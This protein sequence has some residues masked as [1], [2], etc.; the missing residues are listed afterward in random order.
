LPGQPQPTTLLLPLL[1]PKHLLLDTSLHG[2]ECLVTSL[3]QALVHGFKS[4]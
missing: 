2:S 4:I 3:Q 1:L